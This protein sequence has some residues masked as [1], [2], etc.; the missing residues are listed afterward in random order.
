[1]IY[2]KVKVTAD[3]LIHHYAWASSY[4]P[5]NDDCNLSRYN[6]DPW[7]DMKAH[8]LAAHKVGCLDSNMQINVSSLE[9]YQWV[10]VIPLSRGITAI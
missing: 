6:H 4:W 10:V 9:S 7:S 1:M 8:P 3:D 2:C 5:V